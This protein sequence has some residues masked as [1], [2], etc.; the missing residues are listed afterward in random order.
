MLSPAL[1]Q[2]IPYHLT[3]SCYSIILV[4]WTF[5]R[6]TS[7]FALLMLHPLPRIPYSYL[8]M[9]QGLICASM[10]T[11]KHHYHYEVLP[12][13]TFNLSLSSVGFY[14]ILIVNMYPV[15]RALHVFSFNPQNNPL[16]RCC[17]ANLQMRSLRL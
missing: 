14:G 3:T 13:H 17:Y 16:G 11:Q 1:P 8:S 9:E 5:P 10:F 6:H 2:N 12:I 15:L 4:F 7:H